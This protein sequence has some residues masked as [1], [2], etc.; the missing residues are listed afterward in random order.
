MK[1][2]VSEWELTGNIILNIESSKQYMTHC[3]SFYLLTTINVNVISILTIDSVPTGN[4]RIKLNGR[5]YIC[6]KT[7]KYDP[8]SYKLLNLRRTVHNKGGFDKIWDLEVTKE[9]KKP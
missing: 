6:T 5:T 3:Q 1:I 9:K 8:I 4:M 7:K 2:I